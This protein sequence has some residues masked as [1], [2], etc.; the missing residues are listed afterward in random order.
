VCTFF[1]RKNVEFLL[2]VLSRIPD[3]LDFELTLVGEG[4]QLG[5]LIKFAADIGVDNKVNWVPRLPRYEI[6]RL[7]SESDLHCITSLSE[8]NTTVLYEAISVGLPTISLNCDGM[9][10]TLESGG[11][12]LVEI[13]DY[14]SSIDRYSAEIIDLIQNPRRMSSLR[15]SVSSIQRLYTWDSKAETLNRIYSEV[16]KMS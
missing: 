1:P 11:G 15:E 2:R 4:P 7:L 10:D 12:V 8:A 3:H 9:A 16:L 14:L 6:A 13:G 5:K